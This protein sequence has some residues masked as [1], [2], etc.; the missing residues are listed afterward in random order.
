MRCPEVSV[1]VVVSDRFVNLIEEGFDLAIRI[2][3]L[4]ESSLIA[5]RLTTAH[6]IVCA[7]P[8]YLRRAGRPETPGDLSRHACLIYTETDGASKV[9]KGKLKRYAS[10]GRLVPATPNSFTSWRLPGTA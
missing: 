4:P 10:P 6:L 9:H 1:E 5:R 3:E 7:A 8:A 2:G